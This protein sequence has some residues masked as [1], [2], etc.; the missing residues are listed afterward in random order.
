[1][2]GSVQIVVGRRASTWLITLAT[3][4]IALLLPTSA[5]AITQVDRIETPG[6]VDATT[7]HIG[8]QLYWRD[9]TGRTLDPAGMPAAL[10]AA[11]DFA[12]R[13]GTGTECGLRIVIDVYDMEDAEWQ[14]PTGQFPAPDPD[15]D[16]FRS[17]HEYDVL[18]LRYPESGAED[19][20]GA[21]N[22]N[23]AWFP[24]AGTG[25]VVG[26]APWVSLLM[27]EWLHDVVNHYPASTLGWPDGDVHGRCNYPVYC[28]GNANTSFAELMAYF[29]DMSRG[30][31]RR[32]DG[33]YAGM[34]PGEY[35]LA[36]TPAHPMPRPSLVAAPAISGTGKPGDTLTCSAGTW[37]NQPTSYSFQW[38][39]PTSG[40]FV[41]GAT[42]ATY[43]PRREDGF[44]IGCSVT[45]ISPAGVASTWVYKALDLG[46]KPEVVTAPTITGSGRIGDTLTCNTGTWSLDPTR[47]TFQWFRSD[48][49]YHSIPG[50]TTPTYVPTV[51]D[52]FSIACLVSAIND[53]G[54]NHAWAFKEL[55]RGP[56][57]EALVPPEI[58]GSGLPG[59]PLLCSQGTWGNA[60]TSYSYHWY[61]HTTGTYILGATSPTYVPTYTDT[62]D[63]S[64]YVVATNDA[65]STWARA[66]IRLLSSP[67]ILPT[68]EPTAVPPPP[69][70]ITEPTVTPPSTVTTPQ[71]DGST[72]STPGET[73]PAGTRT[74]QPTATPRRDVFTGGR[75]IDRVLLLAG[76]DVARGGA[77]DD[78]LDGGAGDDRIDGG[79][80]NDMV[81]GG[82][83]KDTLVGGPGKDKIH[84]SAG[85]DRLDG[86]DHAQG[87]LI[88]GGRGRDTC[89]YNKGDVVR[90]CERMVLKT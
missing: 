21:T 83:G 25:T 80:G 34:V 57:P 49:S 39:R 10:A 28:T 11:R 46:P 19:Y 31:V 54:P 53:N 60:P 87:D 72:T 37:S 38:Y 79:T 88:D 35:R 26:G 62:G 63:V 15:R 23:E 14:Q 82:T 12:G 17:L 6:C 59:Q 78:W 89:F 7:W 5:T 40:T 4:V 55:D 27:H 67:I 47:F 61:S 36:G 69:V 56:K 8:Y 70:A 81:R 13:V 65:G 18:F 68:Q 76:N 52:G 16:A 45:A 90:N 32:A 51:D 58:T 20:L 3:M 50:A 84:G 1:M 29:A 30:K 86:N 85:N 66:G 42:D 74:G 33:T 43:V 44:T 73:D 71:I 75:G 77:G 64:C 48:P 2:G 24:I 9:T 22:Y 41:S